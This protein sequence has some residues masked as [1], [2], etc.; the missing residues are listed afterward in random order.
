MARARDLCQFLQA[1]IEE[2]RKA[3]IQYRIEQNCVVVGARRVVYSSNSG[4][5]ISKIEF[6]PDSVKSCSVTEDVF[7]I[8]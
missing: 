3:R 4:R 1:F 8:L 5:F 7:N 2:L 6:K